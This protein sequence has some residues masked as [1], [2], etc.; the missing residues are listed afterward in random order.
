MTQKFNLYLF[1]TFF[2]LFISTQ[3]T[4]AQW[5]QVPNNISF[6][7][8]D[9]CFENDTIGI[10]ASDSGLYT[11]IN[12]GTTWTR[13]TAGLSASNLIIYNRSKFKTAIINFSAGAYYI[14]G[15]DTVL[16][17]AVIFK[18]INYSNTFTLLT[19]DTSSTCINSIIDNY[20]VGNNGYFAKLYPYY[21]KINTPYSNDLY[22]LASTYL[23]NLVVGDSVI[24][25]F[26]DSYILDTYFGERF[27]KIARFSFLYRGFAIDNSHLKVFTGQNNWSTITAIDGPFVPKTLQYI[28]NTPNNNLVYLGT[29]SGI[30]RS[31]TALIWEKYP[32]TNGYHVLCMNRSLYTSTNRVYVGCKNGVLLRTDNFGGS[33]TPYVD[34]S[35]PNGLCLNQSS[36]FT[37][38]GISSNTYTWYLN[39]TQVATGLNYS[40][41]FTSAGSYTISVTA[42]NGTYSSTKSKTFQVTTVPLTTYP[43][44]ISDTLICKEGSADISFAT[45][46]NYV[47][48]KLVELNSNTVV[49]QQV[50]TGGSVVLNTGF[51]TDSTSYYIIAENSLS[52]CSA[53]Y[54]DTIF[55]DVE[56]TKADFHIGTINADIGTDVT[57]Y[58]NSNL[59]DT[60]HW[61]FYNN[62]SISQSTSDSSVNI[63]YQNTGQ[64]TIRMIAISS[65]NCI[66]TA[67]SSQLYVYAADSNYSR[68]WAQ[69]LT[70]DYLPTWTGQAYDIGESIEIDK[71]GN[72]YYSGKLF[73]AKLPSKNGIE[74]DT[75]NSND[76]IFITKY[77][78][79]G[80][81]K[82]AVRS[83][84]EN[85]VLRIED[86]KFNNNDELFV[87]VYVSMAFASDSLEIHSND[88]KIFWIATSSTS[89]IKMDTNGV[90]E[91]IKQLSNY[92]GRMEFDRYGNIYFLGQ[93][94]Y[95]TNTFVVQKYDA[96]LNLK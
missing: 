11:T 47:N 71:S 18:R 63:S 16:N 2:S 10:L 94:S 5:T 14:G 40:K 26:S 89:I 6:D 9:I 52:Y 3:I 7:I 76:E 84:S 70:G 32:N 50:S 68:Q 44:T 56:H 8:N 21:S 53:I 58:N 59:F 41:T 49:D 24:Y 31:K 75:L 72:I 83:Y 39:G 20:A 36:T 55:I 28:Y 43:Y 62:A 85:A 54:P 13:L 27:K 15:R 38:N 22:D 42:T 82:W 91:W 77:D 74:L 46:E 79:N 25:K 95:Y 80:T 64:K 29:E 45:S 92:G 35:A 1:L 33:T 4:K 17:C 86:M 12:G 90:I 60:I 73:H 23:S 87:N 37:V 19:S 88:G 78:T 51:I 34:F 67:I 30:Y 57:L 66:D 61:E 81:L 48:Y 69:N 96:N 65:A 93:Y